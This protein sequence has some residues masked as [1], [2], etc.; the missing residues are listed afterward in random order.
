MFLVS[1]ASIHPNDPSVSYLKLI[2]ADMT[3]IAPRKES[4][5][6]PTPST[7]PITSCPASPPLKPRNQPDFCPL[8][9]PTSSLSN[10]D[11][12]EY[13]T[14]PSRKRKI[15]PAIKSLDKQNSIASFQLDIYPL[16]F[17]DPKSLLLVERPVKMSR[18]Q[19]AAAAASA[20][21]TAS[22][23]VLAESIMQNIESKSSA[24]AP[25]NGSNS[26]E[27]KLIQ[28]PVPVDFD[29]SPYMETVGAPHVIW[30]KGIH[31]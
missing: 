19:R 18:P 17:A 5:E 6:Y 23:F 9:S 27:R 1:H 30:K 10:K 16:Y 21:Y 11:V 28:A 31:L 13:S 8:D 26:G 29:M 12:H 15:S 22:S 24:P 4:M 7:S 3:V 20:T 2:H 14:K 25:T